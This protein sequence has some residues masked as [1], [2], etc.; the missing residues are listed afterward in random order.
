[1]FIWYLGSVTGSG[2]GAVAKVVRVSFKQEQMLGAVTLRTPF[3]KQSLETKL[4]PMKL[5][6]SRSSKR[7]FVVGF[8]IQ[9]L[10]I[11]V[12]GIIL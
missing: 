12:A 10:L 8:A 7:E 4:N 2:I 11:R 1:M 3:E 6:N 9:L 5:Q